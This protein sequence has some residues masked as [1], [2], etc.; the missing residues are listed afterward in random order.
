MIYEDF[1]FNLT[2]SEIVK[3][4]LKILE[5]LFLEINFIDNYRT[6]LPQVQNTQTDFV[7]DTLYTE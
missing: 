4:L 1:M 6:L 5:V 7:L 2:H 3:L